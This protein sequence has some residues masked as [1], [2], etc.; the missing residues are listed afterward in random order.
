MS[1]NEQTGSSVAW[2]TQGRPT[3][4]ASTWRL[5]DAGARR[6][7]EPTD[8]AWFRADRGWGSAGK[9]KGIAE[10]IGGGAQSGVPE[11]P[12]GVGGKSRLG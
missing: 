1:G 2:Q 9:R 12:G 3:K 10:T 7:I 4:R 6:G 5:E 11:W 8:R